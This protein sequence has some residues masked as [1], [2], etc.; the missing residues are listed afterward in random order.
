VFNYLNSLDF[1]EPSDLYELNKLMGI[2]N[3]NKIRTEPIYVSVNK[4]VG[5]L[6]KEYYARC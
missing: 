6:R 2:N 5:D 3:S 4:S 1:H